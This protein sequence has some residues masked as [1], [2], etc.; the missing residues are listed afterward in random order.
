MVLVQFLSAAAASVALLVIV[1]SSQSVRSQSEVS[2]SVSQRTAIKL[3]SVAFLVK[4]SSRQSEV[5]QSVRS[6]RTSINLP[7]VASSLSL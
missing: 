4:V 5:S 7:T 3:P 2:Q 6:Q 1:P